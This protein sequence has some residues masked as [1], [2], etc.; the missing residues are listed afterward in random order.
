MAPRPNLVL[1][2]SRVLLTTEKVDSSSAGGALK[3]W[4]WL[5]P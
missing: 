4:A 3:V 5:E 2:L 1:V